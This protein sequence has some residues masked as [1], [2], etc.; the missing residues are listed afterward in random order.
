MANAALLTASVA[1]NREVDALAHVLREGF[2]QGE[3][4]RALGWPLVDAPLHHAFLAYRLAPAFSMVAYGTKVSAEAIQAVV[5]L[6]EAQFKNVSKLSSWQA[7]LEMAFFMRDCWWNPRD[8]A[9][10]V[11]TR[12]LEMIGGQRRAPKQLR[13]PTRDM[14]SRAECVL[15][16]LADYK[17]V[18]GKAGGRGK[19]MSGWTAAQQF[20]ES[21][22]VRM[23]SR[24]SEHTRDHSKSTRP[25]LS[26]SERAHRAVKT[27]SR[28]VKSRNGSPSKRAR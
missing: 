14:L 1:N 5:P 12:A 17:I 26:D 2:A 13:E 10:S 6:L 23:N 8:R 3:A 21:F 15:Q 28:A 24:K 9:G 20:A 4:L 27:A 7:L 18:Q 22:G 19:R 11:L 25:D 16:R